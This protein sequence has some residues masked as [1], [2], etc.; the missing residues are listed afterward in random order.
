MFTLQGH[1]GWIKSVTLS[2]DG[3]TLAS[4]SSDRTVRLWD[5][6]NGQP[7]RTLQGHVDEV[8]DV[9]LSADGRTPRLRR[10]ETKLCAY[11]TP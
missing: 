9:A 7:L 6:V 4:A 1:Q 2:A 5:A 8:M 3:R 11:G 10:P